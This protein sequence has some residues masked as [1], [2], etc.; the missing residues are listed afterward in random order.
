M[1]IYDSNF[2]TFYIGSNGYITFTEGFIDYN[3]SFADHF[4]TMQISAL[5]DDL[6]PNQGGTISWKQ[7]SD[8]AVITWEEVPDYN[9]GNLNTFQV[10]M[11]FDGQIR[12]AWLSVDE[13]QDGLVGLSQGLGVPDDFQE[14]DITKPPDCEL[15]CPISDLNCDCFVDLLDFSILADKWLEWGN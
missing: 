8:R 4:D 1:S 15:F 6:S 9:T 2:S 3:E 14:T 11:Y 13:V 5:F 10:E 12:M 7:M